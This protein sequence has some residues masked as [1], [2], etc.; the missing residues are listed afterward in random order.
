MATPKPLST[1]HVAK[2]CHVSHAAVCNWV[3]GGKL[4][5]YRTPGGQ[6]RIEPHQLKEFMKRHGMPIPEELSPKSVKRI[7]VVD[8]EPE[9]V[10]LARR[11]LGKGGAG[12][13]VEAAQDGYT[14]GRLVHSLLPDLVVLDIRMPGID[15][16]M[17]CKNIKSDPATKH[18]KVLIATAYATEENVR[19]LR[20][21]GAE[22]FLEG[23]GISDAPIPI[24]VR[25]KV[26]G[27]SLSMDFEGTA[28]AAQ[29]NVNCPLSVTRSAAL[30]VTRCLIPED[31]PTN[32]GVAR[33]IAI[34]APAGCLVNARAPSA[35]AAG[36]VETSQRIADLLFLALAQAGARV[37][38]QGQGTMN[39][40]I[41]GT[42]DWTYYET[43]G[44]GQGAGP[45]GRG[46]S[47]V[48]VGMSNTLNTPIEVLEMET[49]V[50][51]ERYALREGTGG[52]GAHAGGRGVVRE[53]RTLEPCSLSLITE[54]R[55]IAPKGLN[56]GGDGAPGRNLVNGAEVGS[57]VAVEL[58][59][60]DVV[61]IETPGGGG[62][63]EA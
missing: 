58:R 3:K 63:G 61:T 12:Y 37:A 39:N 21:L 38:A 28:P 10:D 31:V 15:G 13:E 23:D 18:T 16:I 11:A 53:L 29:G 6:Y 49:P 26:E 7:V 57:K 32:G 4:K 27:G 55:K 17:V 14:A 22:D 34:T 40:V 9:I 45:G 47:G 35:V 60:G 41:L 1:T 62:Y 48:H 20:E 42:K 25:V 2:F 50:R 59:A 30:F 44:G 36:N 46:P 54:R 56:G 43:I 24:R 33:C 19:K 8:D 51:V 5:A 52:A